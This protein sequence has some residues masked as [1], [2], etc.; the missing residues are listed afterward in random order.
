M[1]FV[2]LI[3]KQLRDARWLLGLSVAAFVGLSWL[4]VFL[5]TRFE[6][7]AARGEL[8]P[9]I[10]RFGFLRALGGAAMDYSTIALEVCWWNHPFVLLIVLSW[11][12]ARG[13]SAVAGEIERGT[14][15][16]TLSRPVSRWSFLGSQVAVGIL[17]LLAL[18]T[19]LIVGNL[20]GTRFNPVKTPPTVL[21]L[22]RPAT[23]LVA[24]GWSI[25]GYTIAF[26]AM[27]SVR[28]RPGV[29]GMAITLG[30]LVAMTVA[31]QFD[32]VK[33]L[34]NLSVFQVY[35]PVTAA[36]DGENLAR[37]AGILGLVGLSGVVFAF[38]A[39]A[40][41]DLPAAS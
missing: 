1:V 24:L 27:D 12:V 34:E 32:S 31:P 41:R 9:N 17:G 36:V 26:S 37:E 28:W 15:D 39:F 33:W 21:D 30:G 19:A 6:R 2:T 18:A 13:A 40:R 16:L 29:I 10:R 38:G 11:A 23:L 14:L 25:F 35:A 4:S 20:L 7:L 22:L 3:R 5:T 8:G